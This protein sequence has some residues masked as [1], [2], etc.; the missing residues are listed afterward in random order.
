MI[1]KLKD[2]EDLNDVWEFWMSMIKSCIFKSLDALK[3][4]DMEF[5][6]LAYWDTLPID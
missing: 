4:I 1:D 6:L 2:S 3:T 5:T